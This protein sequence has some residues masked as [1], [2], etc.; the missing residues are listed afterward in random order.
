MKPKAM[1]Y[2]EAATFNVG[3]DRPC[4]IQRKARE[5]VRRL[6]NASKALPPLRRGRG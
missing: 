3:L 5:A 4:E 6:R 2:R 1:T